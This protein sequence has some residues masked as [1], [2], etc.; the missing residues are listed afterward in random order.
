MGLIEL[1]RTTGKKEYLDLA[2]LVVELRD[3]V[4]NGLDDNQDRLPLKQHRKI[5]GHAVRANYLYA[6]VTDL[7][8]ETGDKD[9]REVLTSVWNHL[10]TQ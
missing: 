4:K 10:V 3:S 2:K 9:Y 1:Y 6:G 7:Y 8:M 5:V